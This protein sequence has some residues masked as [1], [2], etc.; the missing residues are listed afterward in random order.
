MATWPY[1]R[2]GCP[3]VWWVVP[4]VLQGCGTRPAGAGGGSELSSLFCQRIC[5][6]QLSISKGGFSRV[7]LC[8]SSCIPPSSLCHPLSATAAWALAQRTGSAQAQSSIAQLFHWNG[9]LNP[10]AK[11]VPFS[12]SRGFNSPDCPPLLAVSLGS[13]CV[14]LLLLSLV[15]HPSSGR[16]ISAPWSL[17]WFLQGQDSQ[18]SP[19]LFLDSAECIPQHLLLPALA[20]A[21]FGPWLWFLCL[22][23]HGLEETHWQAGQLKEQTSLTGSR[24]LVFLLVYTGFLC[25]IFG[26]FLWCSQQHFGILA[27]PVVKQIEPALF[28]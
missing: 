12:F 4:P 2:C 10:T 3:I 11:Y 20:G 19:L 13:S 7:E 22:M 26:I 23:V 8:C 16:V 21:A 6:F 9:L 27:E 18:A 25:L 15:P 14:P 24:A 28:L 5:R 1:W 17:S